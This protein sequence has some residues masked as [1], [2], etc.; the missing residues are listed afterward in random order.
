MCVLLHSR[1]ETSV[2][3][4]IYREKCSPLLMPF[5]LVGWS[6]LAFFRYSGKQNLKR[7]G[8]SPKATIPKAKKH[9]AAAARNIHKNPAARL[10]LSSPC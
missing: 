10:P 9:I 3:S 7:A 1:E 2:R 4:I 5:R 8:G 6:H